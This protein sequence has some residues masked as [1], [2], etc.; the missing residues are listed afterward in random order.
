MVLFWHDNANGD[1]PEIKE[2]GKTLALTVSEV[3]MVATALPPCQIPASCE[4]V[5][6]AVEANAES[7]MAQPP[8]CSPFLNGPYHCSRNTLMLLRTM[9]VFSNTWTN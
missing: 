2:Q 6:G 3:P 4:A 8:S 7:R 1:Y 9:F 5:M